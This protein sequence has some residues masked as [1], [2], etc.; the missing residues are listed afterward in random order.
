MPA[1]VIGHNLRAMARPS[2]TTPPTSLCRQRGLVLAA[3]CAMAAAGCHRSTTDTPLP[4]ARSGPSEAPPAP[5]ETPAD[6]AAMEGSSPASSSG[7]PPAELPDVHTEWCL[8]GWRGLD[9]GTCYLVPESWDGQGRRR[10]LV[11][12]SGIVPPV[13]RSPQ[14]ENVQRIVAAAAKRAGAVALL[15]RGRRG[16]GPKNAKDWWAWPTSAADHETF[17]A[18]MV[19]EWMVA[20]SKLEAA[21]GA[22]FERTYLAG[23]SSGAYFLTAL[24]LGGAVEMNGYA[25]TSGGA[26]GLGARRASSATKR[27]FYVGYASGDPTKGGPKALGAFLASAGLPVRVAEHPGGHEAREVYLDEAFAFWEQD[28]ATESR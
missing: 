1:L 8:E 22:A 19:A 14:K 13:P 5:E 27:P 16:I 7:R 24:A 21:L 18:A 23:S 25:A 17:A 6:A 28:G 15:P 9:E 26:P 3:A 12:L 4:A 10:L 2:M 20:R 11:Y